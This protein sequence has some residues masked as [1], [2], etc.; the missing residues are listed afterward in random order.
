MAATADDLL[1][2]VLWRQVRALALVAARAIEQAEQ[3]ARDAL[4]LINETDAVMFRADALMT[5]ASV[6]H[7]AG[8]G[9][10]AVGFADEAVHFYETKGD[11][12]DAVR[13]KELRVQLPDAPDDSE[14][15]PSGA[16]SDASA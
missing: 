16:P 6:L 13:A 4:R 1:P 14:G 7:V 15:A 8:R 5:L 12:V 2:Q 11:V 9:A 3:L 10:Q